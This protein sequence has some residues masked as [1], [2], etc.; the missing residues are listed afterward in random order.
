MSVINNILHRP[1]GGTNT[2]FELETHYTFSVLPNH[3]NQS[4]LTRPGTEYG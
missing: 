1:G 2:G 4:G 3:S